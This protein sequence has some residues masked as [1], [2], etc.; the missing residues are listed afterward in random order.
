M[1]KL[2]VRDYCQNCP[3]FEADV[4]KPV[5]LHNMS[6]KDMTVDDTIVSCVHE[7]ICELVT[8]TVLS[9]KKSSGSVSLVDGHVDEA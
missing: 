9:D 1:I 8:Q 7:H 5:V 6:G 3:N 2:D 4:I